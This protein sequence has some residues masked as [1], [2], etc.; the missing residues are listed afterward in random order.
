MSLRISKLVQNQRENKANSRGNRGDGEH[1]SPLQRE[2]KATSD[3]DS[4]FPS[5]PAPLPQG[6]GGGSG[7]R[8]LVAQPVEELDLHPGLIDLARRVQQERFHGQPVLAEGRFVAYVR[9]RLI[10]LPAD[11]GMGD[12]DAALRELLFVRGEVQ[13]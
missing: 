13:G 5:P 10:S 11:F 12:V 8:H 1:S 9:D 2:N 6:E 4:N 7:A 3:S